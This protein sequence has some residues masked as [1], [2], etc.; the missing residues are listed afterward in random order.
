ML[1]LGARIPLSP[2]KMAR[3]YTASCEEAQRAYLMLEN[4]VSVIISYLHQHEHV[5]LMVDVLR[6]LDFRPC[7]YAR[8]PGQNL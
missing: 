8:V 2:D 4:L 6:L 5:C 3:E 1:Y 7:A